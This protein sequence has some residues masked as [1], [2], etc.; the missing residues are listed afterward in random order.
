MKQSS[1]LLSSML[2]ALSCFLSEPVRA[3]YVPVVPVIGLIGLIAAENAAKK[4]FAQQ[5]TKSATYWGQSFL[6][7]R[8]PD[9]MLTGNAVD[10]I[11][12]VENQLALC[13][14]ALLADSTSRT[15][16]PE[17]LADIRTNIKYI[18]LNRPNWDQQAYHQELN[19]YSSEDKRRRLAAK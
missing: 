2:F 13:Y 5:T 18:D 19:F 12:Q 11:K 9:N 16:P 3:Q 14:M 10:R 4:E 6:I 8:T 17:R 7:K 1:L 15:C